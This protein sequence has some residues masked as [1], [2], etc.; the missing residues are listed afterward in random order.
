MCKVE[1]PPT[2]SG[3]E[4]AALTSEFSLTRHP[5]LITGVSEIP[6]YSGH[7]V[8]VRLVI[9]EPQ[10]L[11]CFFGSAI[12][13]GNVKSRFEGVLK[14]QP[15]AASVLHVAFVLYRVESPSSL[16]MLLDLASFFATRPATS[17]AVPWS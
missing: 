16:H 8:Q 13:R 4:G 14:G 9:A 5:T 3:A 11:E 10:H 17:I 6:Q 12:Y 1:L 15:A 7:K 2:T